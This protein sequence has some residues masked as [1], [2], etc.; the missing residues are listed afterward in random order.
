MRIA[1]LDYQVVPTN[2]IGNCDRTIIDGLADEHEFVVFALQ[3]DNPRPDRIQFV[4]I[5]AVRKPLFAL[6]ASYHLTAPFVLRRYERQHG[7][8]DLVQSI[9]SN[10]LAGDVVYAHFCHTA[11][12]RNYWSSTRPAGRAR[13]VARWL[14]HKLHA[15]LERTTYKRAKAIAIPSQG[16]GREMRSI[17]AAETDGKVTVISNPVDTARM[18]RPADFDAAAVRTQVGFSR[19]DFVMTFIALGHYE[20]KGLP[21]LLEAMARLKDPRVKLL[22]VGGQPGV[23]QDYTQRA[24]QLGLKGQIAFTGFQKDVRPYLWASDVFA[25]PSYYEV[26]SLVT[27]EAAASG[28]PLVVSHLNGVEEMLVDGENGWYV[29]RDPEDIAEKIR[30]CAAHPEDVQRAGLAAVESV[31]RFDVSAF[32]ERW[33]QYYAAYELGLRHENPVSS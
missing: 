28:L 12:L 27:L 13:R 7:K 3:F 18:Q 11:F 17:Y 20:R 1:I 19:D 5:P 32:V 16:L 25:F 29:E 9:E 2:A 33:R 10:T 26:F 15:M 8:F 6:F 24:E 21:L 14:D 4:K 30:Y 23:I 31:R 22:V